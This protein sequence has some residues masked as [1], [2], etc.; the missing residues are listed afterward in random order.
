MTL[1]HGNFL[2]RQLEAPSR[3]ASGLFI[4]ET[5]QVKPSKAR[6]L[7]LSVHMENKKTW[8]EVDDVVSY[9]PRTET[10]IVINGEEL[11]LLHIDNVL[12][13]L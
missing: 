11:I 13:V 10:P 6:V 5:A 1:L 2:A 7:K 3:T 12:S 4:P 9:K 8:V